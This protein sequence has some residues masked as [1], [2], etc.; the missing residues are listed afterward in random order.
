MPRP[1]GITLTEIIVLL[2]IGGVLLCLA[3]AG[4]QQARVKSRREHCVKRLEQLA[5]GL[6]RYRQAHDDFFPYGTV[7]VEKLQVRNMTRSARGTVE[8]PGRNVGAKA[9]LNQAILEGGWSKFANFVAYKSAWAGSSFV[10]VPAAYSLQTCAVC[11]TVDKASR[12]SQAEFVCVACGHR[13]HA[14]VNA[15]K[16]L[17]GRGIHGQAACGGSAEVGRP[18]KQELR[19]VRRGPRRGLEP[20]APDFRPG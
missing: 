19:V 5:L 10:E 4:I 20:K 13:D 2:V 18:K 8:Q 6:L 12:P 11:G 7:V 14:D 16:V 15:A 1:R 17:L 9:G 3:V